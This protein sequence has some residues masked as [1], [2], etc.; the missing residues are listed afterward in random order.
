MNWKFWK[1]QVTQITK[2]RLVVPKNYKLLVVSVGDLNHEP[3]KQDIQN[4]SDTVNDAIKM[5][6]KIVTVPYW[7]KLEAIR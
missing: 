4:I 1:K 3:T 2:E 6:K 5:K 7:I